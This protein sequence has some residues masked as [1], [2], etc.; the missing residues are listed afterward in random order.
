[1][2]YESILYSIQVNFISENLKEKRIIFLIDFCKMH[3]N[4]IAFQKTTTK[5]NL[6]WYL[7]EYIMHKHYKTSIFVR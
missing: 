2:L 4:A 7:Y 5:N 6:I 3:K 1:M